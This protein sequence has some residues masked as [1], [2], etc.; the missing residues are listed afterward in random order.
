MLK[1]AKGNVKSADPRSGVSDQVWGGGL[2]PPY[3]CFEMPPLKVEGGGQN[4][5][6]GRVDQGKS[7]KEQGMACK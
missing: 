1:Q 5:A 7:K 4:G 3:P 6:G 2:P